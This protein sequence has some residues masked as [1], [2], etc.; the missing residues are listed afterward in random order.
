M[1]YFLLQMKMG[2]VGSRAVFFNGLSLA[3]KKTAAFSQNACV[4]YLT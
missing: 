3:K 1:L 4:G 2:W